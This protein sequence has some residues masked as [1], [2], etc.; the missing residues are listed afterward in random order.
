VDDYQPSNITWA[1]VAPLEMRAKKRE[2]YEAMS[3][4]ALRDLDAWRVRMLERSE[5]SDST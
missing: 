5:S 1:H 4:R 3:E 2:R